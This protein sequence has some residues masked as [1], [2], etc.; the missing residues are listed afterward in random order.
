MS[1]TFDDTAPMDKVAVAQY[2]K[3]SVPQIL[4]LVARGDIPEGQYIGGRKKYW[5]KVHLD[6]YKARMMQK[7]TESWARAA[8]P[9]P[10]APPATPPVPKP[11]VPSAPSTSTR[12]KR[13]LEDHQDRARRQKQHM[14]D[15]YQNEERLDEDAQAHMKSFLAD[16]SSLLKSRKANG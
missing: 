14:Q 1:D 10:S 4:K 15:S 16:L 12:T 3:C 7:A 13:Q 5:F 6:Q 11:S 9:A 2:L 8:L